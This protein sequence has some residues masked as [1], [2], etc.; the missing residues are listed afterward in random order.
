MFLT[1]L[2][3]HA[4]GEASLFKSKM[5]KAGTEA[6]ENMTF[7]KTKSLIECHLKRERSH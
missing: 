7:V 2:I 5:E 3:E 4:F 1:T 6:L